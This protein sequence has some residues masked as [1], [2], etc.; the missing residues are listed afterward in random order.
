[1]KIKD[2]YL[3]REVAGSWVVV[4]LGD[5]TINFNGMMTLN[6][7]GRMLWQSLERG[8]TREE[9]SKVLTERYEVSPEDALKDV[10]EFV[11]KLQKYGCIQK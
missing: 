4:S 7:S 8:C 9:L 10:D 11:E 3:L 1:V 6:T 2:G 5:E